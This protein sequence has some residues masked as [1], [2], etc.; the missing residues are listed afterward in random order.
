MTLVGVGAKI[1]PEGK[2]KARIVDDIRPAREGEMMDIRQS[3]GSRNRILSPEQVRLAHEHTLELLEKTGVCVQSE[4]AL[5][6]LGDAGCNIKDPNRVKI[7]GKLVTKA[8]DAAPG[9]IEVYDRKGQL[10]MTLREDACYYGTGSDCPY[11]IDLFSGERRSCTKKDVGDLARFCDALPNIDFVMSMGIPQDTPPGTSFVH[12]YQAM[13]RNT[14]KPVIVTG[15]GRRDMTAMIDMALAAV[16]GADELRKRPPLVLYS[17]PF[18]PLTHTDMGIVKCLVCCQYEIPF[19]YI[20]S[21]MMGGSGPATIAGSLVQANAECLSG[22]VIFQTRYPG[23]KFIYGGDASAID[24]QHAVYLYGAPELSVLNAALADLAHYY[25][26]PFFCISGA[27]DAKVLD[28]QAGVEYA[29][30]LYVA[31]LNGCNL[32]HDCGYLESG[33]T[34]SFESILMADEIISLVKYMLRPLEINAE[35][36][37][38]KVIDEVG[39]GGTYLTHRH[40]RENFRRSMWFP[41]FFDRA[42]LNTWEERGG[43]DLRQRLREESQKILAAHPAPELPEAVVQEIGRIAQGH[44]PD[45]R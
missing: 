4:E 35:N 41:R 7:P 12:Q 33:L 42:R 29:F 37:A 24:M 15:H 8:I 43:Q 36:T 2:G 38:L 5:A 11:H 40:T 19:I 3:R 30:S 27:T 10:A 6:I 23:A 9:S 39:P 44:V 45:S 14:T 26:L 17:E 34:S 16:G 13:L 18:S 1:Y 20:P 21:P 28:A 22:L 25:H 31:T 32:I